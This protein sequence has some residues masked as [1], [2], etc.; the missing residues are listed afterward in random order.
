M[1]HYVFATCG[2]S[3]YITHTSAH[4]EIGQKITWIQITS[5]QC[6]YEIVFLN[7][8]STKSNELH[9]IMILRGC[10]IETQFQIDG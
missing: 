5:N 9:T 3:C 8:F 2:Y 6:V 7:V 4:F 10:W 1:L